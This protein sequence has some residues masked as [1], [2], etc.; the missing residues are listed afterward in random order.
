M[1]PAPRSGNTRTFALPATFEPGALLWPTNGTSAASAC[2]SPS[3]DNSGSSSCARRVASTTLSTISCF[4]EPF[5]EKLSIATRGSSKPAMA[6]AVCAVQTAICESWFASGCGVTATSAT[7]R[8]PS[9]P[10]SFAFVMS[11]M[12][13]LTQLIPGVVLII[14]NAGRNTLPVVFWAPATCPSASPF[15]MMRQPRY[16][17]LQTSFC[18]SS[19]VMPF[20]LRN[21]KSSVAYF[22]ASGLLHGSMIVAFSMFA[23]P[24]CCASE[25]ISSLLPRRIISAMPSATALSAAFNVRSSV[26]SGRTMRCLFCWARSIKFLITSIVYLF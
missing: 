17:G 9:S 25:R 1:L 15:L 11:I 5:V 16:N 6:F 12:A 10:Y 3:S 22:S 19:I 23:R 7:K 14:C 13:P 2:N 26:P 18:A 8:T 21:S 4:A 24:C 20:A